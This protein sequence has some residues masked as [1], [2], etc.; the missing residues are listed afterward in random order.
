MF[1]LLNQTV[2][3]ADK[4]GITWLVQ[5]ARKLKVATSMCLVAVISIFSIAQTSNAATLGEMTLLSSQGEHLSAEVAVSDVSALEATSLSV[6]IADAQLSQA[7]GLVQTPDL[8]FLWAELRQ[9]A[10][11]G[12]YVQLLSSDPIT[13]PYNEIIIELTWADGSYLREYALRFGGTGT[14]RP[15]ERKSGAA[16][17]DIATTGVATEAG[18]PAAVNNSV[19]VSATATLAAV[20]NT[21][22]VKRG[23][24]LLQIV[25]GL[26]LPA[27]VTHEQAMWAI[28]KANPYSFSGSP[29]ELRA[30]ATLNIPPAEQLQQQPL[31]TALQGLNDFRQKTAQKTATT[32]ATAPATDTATTAAG[33]GAA[34]VTAAPE[35]DT[36]S[37]SVR[38]PSIPLYQAADSG[39]RLVADS[40]SA[41]A[42]DLSLTR[43]VSTDSEAAV[44]ERQ[45]S[46]TRMEQTLQQLTASIADVRSEI[47][48]VE[49]SVSSLSDNLGSNVG[50]V[51]ELSSLISA[52]SQQQVAKVSSV[53]PLNEATD[54]ATAESADGQQ[55][56]VLREVWSSTYL[57]SL[58]LLT[59]AAL[60]ALFLVLKQLVGHRRRMVAAGSA[61]K[62][63]EATRNK[64]SLRKHQRTKQGFEEEQN[65]TGSATAK[66]FAAPAMAGKTGSGRSTLRQQ[67][68]AVDAP[69][70]LS[71]FR[72]HL[73]S[74]RVSE[75][76][77]VKALR[78]YPNRQDLRL[79]LMERYANRQE[80]ESFA[81][82]A[83]EMF[84]LTRGR[85]KEWPR[86]IQLG[87]ALE[88]EME[89]MEP[90]LVR[91]FETVDFGVERD[92]DSPYSGDS[93]LQFPTTPRQQK[94]PG[95]LQ[96]LRRQKTS[97]HSTRERRTLS[98]DVTLDATLALH[99]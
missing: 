45:Q 8:P 61:E 79:R 10:A 19:A 99:E 46:R 29:H 1:D 76:D 13:D 18:S 75:Q 69:T 24:T 80:V 64:A 34:A 78:R 67:E 47:S 21:V 91:P 11:T 35:T 96:P 93:T 58:A 43:V 30:G 85:N 97:Q 36:G 12:W 15:N 49:S 4:W 73:R 42:A 54:S 2:Q 60:L 92:I 71:W 33:P 31:H 20:A 86:A 52:V 53:E 59:L 65:Q 9:R 89:S 23:D 51:E 22:A 48:G 3:L 57:R 32:G 72:E 98:P 84:H 87:L 68:E 70:A 66:V 38:D 63:A 56:G 62:T 41:R 39:S 88:L 94:R 7:A 37:M 83:R 50:R 40:T 95:H 74:G 25:R 17:T 82:L 26:D 55:Q 44:V 14:T 5:A 28:F 77:L 27:S 81:Q 90:H 16:A 6:S